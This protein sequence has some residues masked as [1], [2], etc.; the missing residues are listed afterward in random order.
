MEFGFPGLSTNPDTGLYTFYTT[1]TTAGTTSGLTW[2]DATYGRAF[3]GQ[4][5]DAGLGYYVQ[6]TTDLARGVT[7]TNLYQGIS[8]QPF[9]FM[10]YLCGSSVGNY[11]FGEDGV[12]YV[13]DASVIMGY[14]NGT[15][16]GGGL[17]VSGRSSLP[18]GAYFYIDESALALVIRTMS[19]TSASTKAA[20][21]LSAVS[22]A[23]TRLTNVQ[24]FTTDVVSLGKATSNRW[25][26]IFYHGTLTSTITGTAISLT[27]GNVA[28]DTTTGTKI[29]TGTTQKLGFWNVTPIVQPTTAV[30]AATF[31]AN[32]SLI[33]NDS[34]TFDGYTIGQVVKAL[35]NEGLLA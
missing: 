20:Q 23:G 13:R 12:T 27:A 21:R 17:L 6:E 35:R 16:G 32:T 30:A 4:S 11:T 33:A 5:A 8:T 31:V 15:R 18:L 25:L 29:G 9:I 2:T 14:S 19:G 22:F 10:N 7:Y 28:T 24:P 3:A 26:D 34:A 1:P